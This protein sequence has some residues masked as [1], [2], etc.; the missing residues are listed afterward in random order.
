MSI[1]NKS[2]KDK[3]IEPINSIPSTSWLDNIEL[4]WE[5]RGES[6]FYHQP[7]E[8]QIRANSENII[9]LKK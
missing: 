1:F 4:S 5:V 3:S 7:E 2:K 9:T 6:K 8:Y